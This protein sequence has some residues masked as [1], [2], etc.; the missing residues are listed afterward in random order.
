[1]LQLAP[2]TPRRGQISR[3][4]APAALLG[5]LAAIVVVLASPPRTVGTHGRAAGTTHTSARRIPP[6]WTVHPGDTYGQI[7]AKT[8]LTIAQLEAFNPHAD[9]NRLQPGQRLNLWSHPPAPRPKLP[10]PRFWT[11]RTGQ[12]F[13]SIAAHIGINITKLEGPKPEAEADHAATRRSRQTTPLSPTNSKP[14]PRG[15][16][17][18]RCI[19]TAS[20]IR[21]ND[22]GQRQHPPAPSP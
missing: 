17:R 11:V 16:V 3:Y 2:A 18:S 13:G 4:L 15:V 10:G 20:D 7:A 5:V 19:H 6:Y 9:P 12:S 21:P 8:G 22:Y 1:M 14:L